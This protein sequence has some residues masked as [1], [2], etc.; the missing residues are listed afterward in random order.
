MDS[1]IRE[2]TEIN[3]EFSSFMLCVTVVVIVA[4]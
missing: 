4:G 1:Q 2:A 3:I